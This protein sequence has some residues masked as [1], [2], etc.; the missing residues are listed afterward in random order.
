M[1]VCYKAGSK[2]CYFTYTHTHTHIEVCVKQGANLQPYWGKLRTMAAKTC[3]CV[4][5]ELRMRNISALLT[6]C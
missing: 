2:M 3:H 4:T 6:S 1:C 5:L